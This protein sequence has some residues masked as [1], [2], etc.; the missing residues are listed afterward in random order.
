M[1]TNETSQVRSLAFPTPKAVI[2]ASRDGT[3]RVWSLLADNPPVYDAKISSHSTRFVNS[4][5]YLPPSQQYPEGL[6]LSGGKD[7][8]IDAR[9]PSKAPEE[10]AEG[11]WIGHGDNV[12][13]LDVDPASKFVVSGSWD[14]DA[15][16][17]TVGKWEE[18]AATLHHEGNVW[19]VLAFDSETIVTACTDTKIRLFHKSG[20]LLKQFQGSKHPLRALCRVQKGHPSGADFACADNDGIIALWTL[21]GKQVGTL[22]GHESFIYSLASLPTG[23][24]VSSG[25]D[26]TVRIWKGSE[27][28]QTI[29]HP[30]ISVWAV[31]VCAE[32]GDI[33]S[34]A[35][36]RNVRVFTRSQERIADAEATRRFEDA[37]RD[38]SIPQQQMGEINKEKLPGPEFLTT[39]L[40]TK[41]GQVQMIRERNGSISAHQWSATQ[42]QWISVGTVV[43][44]VGSSGKKV[45]SKPRGRIQ[46]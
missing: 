17:W 31:A 26:R 7:L 3:V 27:C 25:E 23:E 43:D 15:R 46:S 34:G 2:S 9:P 5:A 38:S 1:S 18:S 4:V 40:G 29:T 28:I 42:G 39:K 33:V 22:M 37:V 12:C 11:L 45:S 24:I 41:E 19:A 16:I 13:A 44:S 30:A 35:S 32:T 8:V 36:D 10:N 21:S 14:N 20:K 6:V